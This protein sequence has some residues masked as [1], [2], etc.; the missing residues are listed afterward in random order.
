MFFNSPIPFGLD[1]SDLSIKIIYFKKKIFTNKEKGVALSASGEIPVPPGYFENGEIKNL[2]GIAE[3]IKKLVKK[4][5]KGK[6]NTP[7]AISVLPETKTF[8]KLIEMAYVENEEIYKIIEE[9]IK[10]DIPIPLENAY[11]DW[12]I[13][14]QD[15]KNDVS[16]IL[17]AVA[18]KKIV[19]DYTLLL[20]KAGLK[21]MAFEIESV[22]I[23]RS[24]INFKDMENTPPLAI[25]DLGATRSNIIIFE[26]G[27]IY[28]TSTIPVSGQEITSAIAS[29]MN[30]SFSKA[31][32]VKIAC[33]LDN[34]KCDQITKEIVK[35]TIEKLI[36]RVKEVIDFYQTQTNKKINKI[37]LCG[38]CSNL[39]GLEE[40]I[41]KKIK[42]QTEKGDPWVNTK[43]KK[44]PLPLVES[45]NY[46]TAIGLALRGVLNK[47]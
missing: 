21:P 35:P 4:P 18:P 39:K 23:V 17:V 7:Y 36:K 16:K 5:A 19:D 33:G 47:D 20:K 10:K 44:S 14:S 32:K 42:I 46:T 40:F 11:L 26:N 30:I 22:P 1:I 28:S 24:L 45:F 37:L 34:K 15:P 9:E 31:E 6:I 27:T 2:D 41:Y 13:I 8:I 3:L 38:G 29:K 25:V 12:Q 43:I